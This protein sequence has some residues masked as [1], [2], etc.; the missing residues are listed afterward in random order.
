MED[1]RCRVYFA[2]IHIHQPDILLLDE[3]T[4]HIDQ[5]TRQLLFDFLD[6]YR[7]TVLLVSHDIELLNRQSLTFEITTQGIQAYKG[8]Y[9]FYKMQ[10]QEELSSLQHRI[11]TLSKDLRQ[12]KTDQQKLLQKQQKAVGQHKKAEQKGGLPKIVVNTLKNAAENSSAKSTEVQVEKQQKLQGELWEL[13]RSIGTSQTLSFE[14]Q[15]LE[16]TYQ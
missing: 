6:Q 11:D 3:P 7:G 5:A 16:L 4:N 15:L 13:N 12:V 8:N 1:N 14:L 10:K 9:D 2:S